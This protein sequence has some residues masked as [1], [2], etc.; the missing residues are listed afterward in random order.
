MLKSIGTLTLICGLCLGA[1]QTAAAHDRS[2]DRHHAPR[3]HHV[4]NHR[5]WYMPRWLRHDR[6]FRFWYHRTS[7]RYNHHLAWWQ[8][9]EIYSL[10]RRYIGR[11]HHAVH[12]GHRQRDYDWYRR[13]WRKHDR[14]HHDRRHHSKR[15]YREESRHVAR[16]DHRRRRHDD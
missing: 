14:H 11:R 3:H 5:D 15:K 13:Y 16:R 1:A 8:L 6:G 4:I 9:Y 10:E 12:Y 2:Y 7:L